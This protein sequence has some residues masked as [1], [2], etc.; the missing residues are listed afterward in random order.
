MSRVFRVRI[1]FAFI[2]VFIWLY[3]YAADNPNLRLAGIVLMAL[4]LLLRFAPGGRDRNDSR[5]A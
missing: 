4:S 5:A 2:G 3:A 1:V